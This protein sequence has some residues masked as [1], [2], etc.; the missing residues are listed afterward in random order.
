MGPLAG[1]GFKP[2]HSSVYLTVM[3]EPSRKSVRRVDEVHKVCEE[4]GCV[5]HM[6]DLAANI[7]EQAEGQDPESQRDEKKNYDFN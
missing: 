3:I 5:K 6:Q 1:H 7:L 2:W 4:S